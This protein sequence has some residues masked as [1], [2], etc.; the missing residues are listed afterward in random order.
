MTTTPTTKKVQQV[1]KWL[2][3]S[4]DIAQFDRPRFHP[5]PARMPIWLAERIITDLSVAGTTVLDPMVGSG[6]TAIAALNV[7]REVVGVDLDPMAL[8]LSRVSTTCYDPKRAERKL[9]GVRARAEQWMAQNR[10]RVAGVRDSFDDEEQ[11]FLRY[12]FPPKSQKELFALAT[13]IAAMPAGKYRDLAWVVFSS[14]IIAKS[15]GAS[16]ALDIARSRPHKVLEKPIVS[17]MDSWSKRARTVVARLPFTGQRSDLQKATIHRGDARRLKVRS[18]SVDLIV[19]SP[20]YLNAVDYMRTHKFS[21]VWMG[22]SLQW[23]RGV[24]G[25]MIGTEQGMYSPDSLPHDIEAALVNGLSESRRLGLV[26]RYMSDMRR[27]LLESKR[28]LK[29]GGAMVMALGP[30][31]ISRSDSDAGEIFGEL[32]ESIG[33]E[34]VDSI[35]RPLEGSRR[36]LPPPLAMNRENPLHQRMQGEVFLGL[37]KPR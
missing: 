35:F 21:L 10:L 7:G 24:R 2:A 19:T 22:R 14:L 20:P 32:A 30:S 34:I 16:Y 29:P 9:E 23:L 4:G 17:P 15:A 33:L 3:K 5:F 26:R 13:D 36:S 1:L 12:W 8:I 27:V 11:T 25:Q 6:T 37:R 28:V 18:G 31:V